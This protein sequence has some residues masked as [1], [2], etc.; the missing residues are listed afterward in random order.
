MPFKAVYN[1]VA[2]EAHS[3]DPSLSL[4]T[5]TTRHSRSKLIAQLFCNKVTI[6]LG[7]LKIG[8]TDCQS[9][10]LETSVSTIVFSF[11]FSRESFFHVDG[12]AV[13]TNR[14]NFQLSN[15]T[16]NILIFLFSN[17]AISKSRHNLYRNIKTFSLHR[18]IHRYL[19]P[20]PLFCFLQ[21]RG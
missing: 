5:F 11:I 9:V 1:K 7:V 3:V 10:T 13:E 4:S 8:C 20:F 2:V 6:C 17:L 12:S 15:S 19:E 18:H 16:S 21:S 14:P